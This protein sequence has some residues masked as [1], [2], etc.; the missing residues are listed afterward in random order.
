MNNEL[1]QEPKIRSV[2]GVSETF[3]LESADLENRG[4]SFL[5]RRTLQLA[6]VRR[7]SDDVGHQILGKD[8]PQKD[9]EYKGLGI[10]YFDISA[11][12]ESFHVTEWTIRRDVPDYEKNGSGELKEKKKYIK[13]RTSKNSLYIPPMMPPAL[14]KQQNFL[15]LP[16]VNGRRSRSHA[17]QPMILHRLIGHFCQ[18]RFPVLITSK[19]ELKPKRHTAKD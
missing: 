12:P 5:N 2:V 8:R 1:Y 15:C 10:P 4:K 19:L 11:L 17:L 9:V 3:N 16:K 18:S 13:A 6:G 7:L 14:L